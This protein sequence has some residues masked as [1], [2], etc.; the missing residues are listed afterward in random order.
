MSGTPI[1][2]P[3]CQKELEVPK[4]VPSRFTPRKGVNVPQP[5]KPT[6]VRRP[7][8]VI[9]EP[10]DLQN[11][12]EGKEQKPAASRNVVSETPA[13]A[14]SVAP[15]RSRIALIKIEDK[16]LDLFGHPLLHPAASVNSALD[17]FE[18]KSVVMLKS[19]SQFSGT[20]RHVEDLLSQNKVQAVGM[21]S[22]DTGYIISPQWLDRLINKSSKESACEPLPEQSTDVSQIA[23]V[24]A[25]DSTA[26]ESVAPDDQLFPVAPANDG[27]DIF[28][29][30]LGYGAAH[31]NTFL[32]EMFPRT[33][34]T[35][36]E[37]SGYENTP[38][39]ILQL[40][41]EKKIEPVFMQDGKV[42]WI[43]N[44]DWLKAMRQNEGKFRN[45]QKGSRPALPPDLSV[46]LPAPP[47]TDD[48]ENRNQSAVPSIVE[49]KLIGSA[50]AV[51]WR[52]PVHRSGVI[53]KESD[54]TEGSSPD[55]GL[56]Q[57]DR[58]GKSEPESKWTGG[59]L[60]PRET[61]GSDKSSGQS[62][63]RTQAFT[64]IPEAGESTSQKNTFDRAGSASSRP[65][66]PKLPPG[67]GNNT[68][69]SNRHSIEGLSKSQ[70]LVFGFIESRFAQFG[71]SPTLR[72]IQ[73]AASLSHFETINEIDALVR[74]GV[75]EFDRGKPRGIRIIP[76]AER[77]PA[78]DSIA[79]DDHFMPSSDTEGRSATMV[80]FETNADSTRDANGSPVS[81]LA[82]D[83]PRNPNTTEL[84]PAWVDWVFNSE[85]LNSR[86]Q[87]AGRRVP[88]REQVRGLLTLL[89]KNGFFASRDTICSSLAL[90][91]IRFDGFIAVVM[92]ILNVDNVPIL[93][94]TEAG[95]GVRLNISL[96][97]HQ[98]G[99]PKMGSP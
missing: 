5:P 70:E 2:C 41:R 16:S 6:P 11:T 20:K 68:G 99:I 8:D 59:E 95:D 45:D 53:V 91:P 62:N 4:L 78:A 54:G 81:L 52:R 34:Q 92:R 28:G 36:T 43:I 79:H 71:E 60:T 42:G 39:H 64:P 19:E 23:P 73:A 80:A 26:K 94:K 27:E 51:R 24:F 49:K 57:A 35:L 7:R 89:A 97:H 55:A 46:E 18:P 86:Y 13:S 88:P 65:V 61:I 48:I 37:L 85:M 44:P 87:A 98:F 29:R 15:K 38:N 82:D 74:K 22:G 1:T 50:P 10:P 47:K 17:E 66:P 75:I 32:S 3:R 96:L 56:R 63:Q 33:V 21:P 76:E 25:E 14:P 30:R 69:R 77:L 67:S 72:E 31:M 83:V 90:M 40:R 93:F 84:L 9:F 58:I 12:D